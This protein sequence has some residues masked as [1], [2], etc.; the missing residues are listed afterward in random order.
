MF[1]VDDYVADSPTRWAQLRASIRP[2]AAIATEWDQDGVDLAFVHRT[3]Y[4]PCLATSGRVLAA[5]DAAGPAPAPASSLQ[6]RL[7]DLLHDY[8]SRFRDDQFLKPLNL[9]VLTHRGDAG[10]DGE[11]GGGDASEDRFEETVMMWARELDIMRA[12]RS[13]LGLQFVLVGSGSGRANANANANVRRFTTL[14]EEMWKQY[15]VR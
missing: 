3:A 4:Y 10:D 14:D 11:S 8:V 5:F 2:L 13:Q 6:L 15:G 1:L 12:P 7:D 9:I